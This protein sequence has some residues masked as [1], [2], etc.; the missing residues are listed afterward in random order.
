MKLLVCN[1]GLTKYIYSRNTLH[2]F[3]WLGVKIVEGD[4]LCSFSKLKYV[5]WFL[6]TLTILRC[7]KHSLFDGK[8]LFIFVQVTPDGKTFNSTF[9]FKNVR[10]QFVTGQTGPLIII[11]PLR[12]GLLFLWIL[13]IVYT[14]IKAVRELKQ[15][16]TFI[17]CLPGDVKV[18]Y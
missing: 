14:D 2:I 6:A 11:S 5:T 1:A 9:E 12:C 10:L 13:G 16:K 17:W 7:L 18:Q 8:T 4:S 3:G 15:N